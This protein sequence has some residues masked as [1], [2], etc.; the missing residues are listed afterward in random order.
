MHATIAAL[1]VLCFSNCV[2]GQ[3]TG[4]DS[5]FVQTAKQR[6]IGYYEQ[7][8]RRQS[9]VYEGNQYI[10]HDPRIK[11]HPY[12][13][14]DSLLVGTV[15]YNHVQ[16]QDVKMQYDIVRDELVVQ[17]PDGGYRLRLHTD[18]ITAFSLGP[19]RFARFV[20][21]SVAG[22]RTGFYE[23]IYDGNVKVL[24]KRQKTVQEDISG[25]TYKGEYLVKDRFVIQKE[26]AFHE[27]KSKGS[28]LDLFPDQAKELRKYMRKNR[29]KFNDAQ[30]EQTI[31][32]LA[33]RYDE[34]TN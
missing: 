32:R 7:T 9:H 23:I 3:A 6:A 2:F 14:V 27:V 25:G 11:V 17:P 22:I 31:A 10:I 24:A 30:R 29:L 33:Q 19:H 21:D 28:V 8:V 15:A 26:G 16:Y 34:L 18:K 4:P 20:G 12:Y 5:S 13:V 1:L